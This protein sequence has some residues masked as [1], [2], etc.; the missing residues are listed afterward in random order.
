MNLMWY[1]IYGHFPKSGF[2]IREK[3]SIE[4]FLST[5]CYP[6]LEFWWCGNINYI[7]SIVDISLIVQILFKDTGYQKK[8]EK[9]GYSDH[10]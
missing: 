10:I 4:K 8:N 2:I 7:G 5:I 1:G 3:V 9:I 6:K